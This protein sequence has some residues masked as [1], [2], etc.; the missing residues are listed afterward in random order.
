M[1]C[2]QPAARRP[3][4][5]YGPI[6]SLFLA[7]VLPA[8]QQHRFFPAR[9]GGG[10]LLAA[11]ARCRGLTRLYLTTCWP[12]APTRAAKNLPTAAVWL[13]VEGGCTTI[14]LGSGKRHYCENAKAL[15]LPECDA[16]SDDLGKLKAVRLLAACASPPAHP[17]RVRHASAHTAIPF[18]HRPLPHRSSA[19]CSQNPFFADA[20]L[21]SGCCA[22]PHPPTT[23]G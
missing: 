23:C 15:G 9:R 3:Q 8:L 17:S 4:P 22:P 13:R 20:R 6:A 14:D 11:S 21:D 19:S 2:R 7:C 12:A 16:Y 5:A 18:T 1:G 10:A